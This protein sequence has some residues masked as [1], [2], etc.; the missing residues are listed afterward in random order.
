MEPADAVIHRAA[1]SFFLCWKE[2][3]TVRAGLQ[4]GRMSEGAGGR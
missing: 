1:G 4:A 2:D 3:P